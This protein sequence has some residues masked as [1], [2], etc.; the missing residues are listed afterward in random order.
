MPAN[1]QEDRI[2]IIAPMGQDAVTM[3]ALLDTN[4]FRTVVCSGP[5][6]CLDDIEVG[7][8]ALLLTE[9]A[10]E[11]PRAEEL[12]SRVKSQPPWSEMPIIMLTSGGET[13]VTGLLELTSSP[14]TLLERPMGRA[15][16]LRSLEVALS[17]RHR[18]YQVRDLLEQQQRQQQEL[19]ESEER[20]RVMA[21]GLPLLIW[22]HNARG[23]QQFVNSTFCR[24]FGVTQEE[25]KGD[26]WLSLLHPED[27]EA[28]ASEFAKC[29][30]EHRPFSGEARARRGDGQWCW[31]QGW[32]Q[33]RLSDSG[34]F[35]GMVGASADITERKQA[36]A[37]LARQALELADLN[38]SLDRRVK[39]RTAQLQELNRELAQTEHRERTQLAQAL[40]DGLQQF[41]VAA[42]MHAD[43]V[44]AT[45]DRKCREDQCQRLHKLLNEAITASRSLTFELSPPALQSEGLVP[46]LQ[47]L[48]KWVNEKHQFHVDFTTAGEA[49]IMDPTQRLIL[50]QCARELVL[51]AIKHSGTRTAQ[52]RLWHEADHREACLEV[53]DQ[54]KGFSPALLHR[55]GP[56][57][58]FGGICRRL[59]LI[60]GS[61]D[62][63]SAPGR[64]ARVTLCVP[65]RPLPNNAQPPVRLE[66][67]RRVENSIVGLRQ[68]TWPEGRRVRVLLVDDHQ[69]V[70]EGLAEILRK[71]TDLDL[72]GEAA[73]GL[74]ALESAIKLEPDV[75]LMD[76]HM[77]GLDGIEATRRILAVRPQVRVI[78][79][80]TYDEVIDGNAMRKA[81]SAAYLTKDQPV[82]KLL[83]TIRSVVGA[84]WF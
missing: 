60:G 6:E 64:G 76:V 48:A 9:E 72:V 42:R 7:A 74:E 20:F 39:D 82:G 18:Q 67:I 50:F 19:R 36:E 44:A 5:Q 4:G 66:E 79:L 45:E 81:G 69:L 23:Q 16:L 35:L 29:T 32:A 80:S 46:A 28:Y 17:A 78:G 75:I 1:P 12:L 22:V 57:F 83:S 65:I 51:N 41:L 13:R 84:A 70:R 27:V 8:A 2:L 55:H 47:W 68:G 56:S 77:P 11:M 31:I 61:A 71:E 58:G 40:H 59:E 25:L 33:P 73:D 30:R 53:A 15:T 26:G 54:G 63:E 49:E 14:I 10:L 38:Q 34:E 24:F 37:E 52:I 62:V 21:D 3:A 43:L